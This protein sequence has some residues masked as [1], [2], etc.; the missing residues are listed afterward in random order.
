MGEKQGRI[1]IKNYNRHIIN[2]L[3]LS[4]LTVTG[5]LF[6][7]Y[8]CGTFPFGEQSILISDLSTQYTEFL[9]FFKNSSFFEK[10]YSLSKGLGGA[11]LPLE[12]YYLFSPFNFLVYLFK[13]ENIQAAVLCIILTKF[14]F[15]AV[16]CY[17]YLCAHYEKYNISFALMYALSPFFM[18]NFFNIIWFD[19]FALLPLLALGTEKISEGK[20]PYLFIS[21][22]VYSLISNYYI[23]Y[24]SSIFILLYFFYYTFCVL[25]LEPKAIALKVIQMA[26]AVVFSV[27]LSAP[28]LLPAAYQLTV[29][30][31]ID[32]G[33]FTKT[34]EFWISRPHLIVTELFTGMYI[35]EALPSLIFTSASV[36]LPISFVINK[37]VDKRKKIGLLCLGGFVALSCFL[38]PLYIAWHA[39]TVPIGFPQR[40]SFLYM[41]CLILICR[42]AF[43][44]I[45]KSSIS[46]VVAYLIAYGGAFIFYFKFPMLPW[47]DG[48]LTKTAIFALST[49]IAFILSNKGIKYG[50]L[51]F[52]MVMVVNIILEGGLIMRAAMATDDYS[53]R[54]AAM[55]KYTSDYK[56]TGEAKEK[57][58]DDSLYRM[59]E[60][61]GNRLNESMAIGYN[62]LSH[63][64][65]TFDIAEKFAATHFGYA[66]SLYGTVYTN[67]KPLADSLFGLKYVIKGS[68]GEVCDKYIPMP[69]SEGKQV[70]LNPYYLPMAFVSDDF[71]IPYSEN[72]ME[73]IDNM[74]HSL[75]G[76]NV[77]YEG[78][79]NYDHLLLSAREIRKN[80]GEALVVNGAKMKLSARAQAGQ[81][82]NT[83]IMYEDGWNVKVNGN[84]VKNEKFMGYF[85]SVPL[86]EGENIIDMFYIPKGLKLGL[87]L[88]ALAI[89]W[90][91]IAMK[92]RG[93]FKG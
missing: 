86:S 57:I 30:K 90:A 76:I 10:I 54:S 20:K 70:Y 92:S 56:Q 48:M 38:R 17:T 26:K 80:Q 88:F 65:S 73:H 37:T 19:A 24:M 8:I 46:A 67:G 39:F 64:S 7:L 55:D 87:A 33:T 74:F 22:F 21:A 32:G 68:V 52:C 63:F 89:I 49:L 69:Y 36:I 45:E 16:S 41:F 78:K 53:T 5:F 62:G 72:G 35:H 59:E 6:G 60:V 91:A 27:L 31:L 9:L 13:N 85:L 75:T 18:R 29:G 82:L 4:I 42:E 14:M 81:Y 34:L 40:F 66:D 50:K 15:L 71:D 28:V 11:T 47:Q 79:I 12:A 58:A 1:K 3:I 23:S 25:K 51:I 77:I 84:R 2:V 61:G 93:I 43:E 44:N 83:T